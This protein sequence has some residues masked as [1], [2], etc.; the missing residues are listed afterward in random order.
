MAFGKGKPEHP[1]RVRGV[2]GGVG[3]SDYF[4]RAPNRHGKGKCVPIGE[5]LIRGMISMDQM[6]ASYV[7][8]KEQHGGTV[9]A[10]TFLEQFLFDTPP[11]E[12]HSQMPTTSNVAP[13]YP[14]Q[15]LGTQ[16]PCSVGNTARGDAMDVADEEEAGQTFD[17]QVIY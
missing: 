15:H 13:E 4:G 6:R 7:K 12:Q 8:F 2:R 1:G 5:D 17:E 3:I 10:A 11:S 9:D 14:T 16:I